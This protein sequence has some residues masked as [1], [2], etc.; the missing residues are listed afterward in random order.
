MPSRSGAR[1]AARLE[2]RALLPSPLPYP[3]DLPITGRKED[4]LAALAADQVVIVAGE[5]GSARARSCPRYVLRRA[6]GAP[7]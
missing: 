5:T 2:A 6:G 1:L 7:A 3:E 4:I